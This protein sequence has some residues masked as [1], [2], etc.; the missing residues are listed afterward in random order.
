MSTATTSA[1]TTLDR[2]LDRELDWSPRLPNGFSSHVAMGLTATARLGADPDRLEELFHDWTTGGFLVRRQRPAALAPL[3]D[4]IARRGAADV[5]RERLPALVGHPGAQLFH[6]VIRLDLALDAGHPSQVANALLSWADDAVSP[7]PAPGGDGD[8][9]VD[10]VM[11]RRADG[12]RGALDRLRADDDLI[13]RAARWAA[14]VHEDPHELG[15]L[16]YVTGTRA[17][18]VVSTYLTPDARRELGVRTVQALV[19]AADRF[20]PSTAADPGE[21]DRRRSMPL[22]DWE[23]MGRRA[24]G[25]G[26]PHVMKLTYACRLEEATT[27]D[28][29]RRWVAARHNGLA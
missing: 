11:A 4:E 13:D 7:A 1:A 3:A 26:D 12:D 16:H 27:G 9:D 23:E 6:A 25:S 2:L 14:S 22:P 10:E 5:L 8:L 28:P 29:L 19:R 18:R 20:G 17:I 21:L 15:T 24:I